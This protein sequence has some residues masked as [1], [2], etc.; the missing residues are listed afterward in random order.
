MTYFKTESAKFCNALGELGSKLE[1]ETPC[2]STVI[3]KKV[4][5]KF[6]GD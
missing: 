2:M 4:K 5:A 6:L 1:L 3:Q